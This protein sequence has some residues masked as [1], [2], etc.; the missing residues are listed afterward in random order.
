MKDK[1]SYDEFH[2]VLMDRI[3]ERFGNRKGVTISETQHFF[4]DHEISV[5]LEGVDFGPIIRV[6]EDYDEYYND[7][8]TLKQRVKL[9][10]DYISLNLPRTPQDYNL[11]YIDF[12]SDYKECLSCRLINAKH[13][14]K[15]LKNKPHREFLDL[16][17][18]YT[19][20]VDEDAVNPKFRSDYKEIVDPCD[21]PSSFVYKELEIPVTNQLMRKWKRFDGIT[22]ENLYYQAMENLRRVDFESMMINGSRCITKENETS[23]SAAM[24]RNDLL[25]DYANKMGGSYWI[26][27]LSVNELMVEPLDIPSSIDTMNQS[28]QAVNKE[29]NTPETILSDHVYIYDAKRHRVVNPME[30]DN[31]GANEKA[32]TMDIDSKDEKTKI[33]EEITICPACARRRRGR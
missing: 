19:I 3:Q 1:L 7:I 15:Y 29:A 31:R 32:L 20:R 30:E 16:A 24:L 9:T 2:G 23:A 4:Q 25:E 6:R 11:V 22:E 27:P 14:A 28:L 8:F 12:F 17:I 5:R 13:N 26:V 21:Q 18:V 33:P 10:E